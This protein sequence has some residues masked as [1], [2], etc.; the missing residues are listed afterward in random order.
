MAENENTSKRVAKTA[1]ELLRTSTSKP[2]KQ[3]AASALS[4]AP[5]KRKKK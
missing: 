4:Q 3:V 5:D 2:V 1:S